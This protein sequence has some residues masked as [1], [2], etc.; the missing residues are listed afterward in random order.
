[1]QPLFKYGGDTYLANKLRYFKKRYLLYT[2]LLLSKTK[3]LKVKTQLTFL[4]SVLSIGP[5]TRS[6]N[7]VPVAFLLAVR[8]KV[9]QGR[10]LYCV[11]TVYPSLVCTRVL[12]IMHGKVLDRCEWGLAKAYPCMMVKECHFWRWKEENGNP[13]TF[14]HTHTQTHTHIHTQTERQ[15]AFLPESSPSSASPLFRLGVQIGRASCRER[16]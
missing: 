12:P 10:D 6:N 11:P 3:I 15:K 7:K 9:T 4:I 1:M 5:T 14:S 16:V 2:S 8:S 13:G